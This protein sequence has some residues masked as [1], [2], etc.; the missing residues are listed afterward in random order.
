VP[1]EFLVI[2]Q[3]SSH[4]DGEDMGRHTQL[5][6]V[7]GAS[8]EPTS[9]AQVAP[10]PATSETKQEP[11]QD[12]WNR[13]LTPPEHSASHDRNK[14]PGLSSL[15][16]GGESPRKVGRHRTDTMVLHEGFAFAE[17]LAKEARSPAEESPTAEPEEKKP[18]LLEPQQQESEEPDTVEDAPKTAKL[19]PETPSSDSVPAEEAA[20]PT[21]GSQ[22]F[23]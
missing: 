13:M 2:P 17:E 16:T 21:V 19:I 15:A 7:L 5:P 4:G 20:Q 12:P 9:E 11:D 8:T 18:I 23:Y 6:R 22:V 14:I 10:K 3:R 1:S